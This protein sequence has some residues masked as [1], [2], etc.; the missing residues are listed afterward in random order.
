MKKYDVSVIVPVY[1]V[2]K[3][4][5]KCAVSLFEQDHDSIEYIFVNDCTP[6]NS[7]QILQDVIDM[8]PNRKDD[9]RII[10]NPK[11]IG[12]GQTRKAGFDA[13]SAKYIMFVD[14]DDWTQPDM[15]SSMYQKAKDDDADIVCADN[16][17][18]YNKTQVYQK[19]IRVSTLGDITDA[20]KYFL[21]IM[22]M[23]VSVGVWDK[24]SKREL[25]DS[26]VF[27]DFQYAEDMFINL[28]L[29]FYASKISHLNQAFYHYR[30][31]NNTSL[32]FNST[33]KNVVR[34]YKILSRRVDEFFEKNGIDEGK[35]EYFYMGLLSIAIPATSGNFKNMINEI[36]P[37]A[38]H[39]KY[40]FNNKSLSFFRKIC[41]AS[42]FFGLDFVVIY[43]RKIY[44]LLKNI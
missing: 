26:V 34:D 44:R 16:F 24:L 31:T 15:I 2:E 35:K 42:V 12:L 11:N 29:F 3:F 32:T 17:I 20:K 41:F 28:Q 4:I 18:N 33:S 21:Y 1:N 30:K 14:S 7:M 23:Y 13:S 5:Q 40:I 9:V 10:N 27:P 43:A 22:A 37:K 38:Y 19:H 8:Y 6:D 25:F 36:N 39:I